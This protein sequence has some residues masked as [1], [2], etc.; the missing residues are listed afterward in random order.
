MFDKIRNNK[1]WS[2]KFWIALGTLGV[3]IIAE[4]LGLDKDAVD[5]VVKVSASYLGAQ[6]IVDTVAAI[7]RHAQKK[8]ISEQ[9]IALS[10]PNKILPESKKPISDTTAKET[11]ADKGSLG[12]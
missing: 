11:A 6:G 7:R 1:I 10:L 12:V 2:R 5:Q 8:I 9:E 3:I 4:Q